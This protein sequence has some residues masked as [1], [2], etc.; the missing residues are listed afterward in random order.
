M[1]SN[2]APP[3]ECTRKGPR[4]LSEAVAVSR[5]EEQQVVAE[6]ERL[7]PEDEREVAGDVGEVVIL[8]EQQPLVLHRVDPDL[9]RL[10]LLVLV[11]RAQAADIRRAREAAARPRVVGDGSRDVPALPAQESEAPRE[12][13]VLLVHVE[14]LVQ[15]LAPD[16]DRLERRAAGDERGSAD[17]EDL[18]LALVLT[19]V[20]LV[21]AAIGHAPAAV[22]DESRGVDDVRLTLLGEVVPEDLSARTRSPRVRLEEAAELST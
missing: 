17:A 14:A 2:L 4:E 15:V 6:N 16:L 7:A 13:D 3:S 8:H 12:V 21:L 11:E 19:S 22:D 20:A 1:R 18:F 10:P 9:A 5:G